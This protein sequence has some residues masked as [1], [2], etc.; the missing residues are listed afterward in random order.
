MTKITHLEKYKETIDAYKA[1]QHRGTYAVKKELVN[2]IQ[3]VVAVSGANSLSDLISCLASH[4]EEAGELLRS[5]V[6]KATI[7]NK[8]TRSQMAG[9][10]AKKLA[11]E[12]TPEELA[13]FLE[14]L[15]STRSAGQEVST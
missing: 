15:R 4:P 1:T 14:H 5:V 3:K 8:P 12:A 2:G 11:R 10:L 6:E 7:L 9:P 13:A